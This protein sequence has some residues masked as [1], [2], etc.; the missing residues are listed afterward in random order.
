[1]SIKL[2]LEMDKKREYTHGLKEKESITAQPL[3]TRT[4]KHIK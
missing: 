2:P 1:M 4:K 3:E